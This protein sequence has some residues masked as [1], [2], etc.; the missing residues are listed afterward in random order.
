MINSRPRRPR[1][2]LLRRSAALLTALTGLLAFAGAIG[3][4]GGA[5]DLGDTVTSRLPLGSP[6]LASVALALFVGVPVQ[7]DRSGASPTNAAR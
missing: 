3:L 1:S 2:G 7:S 4:V 6:V 5:T